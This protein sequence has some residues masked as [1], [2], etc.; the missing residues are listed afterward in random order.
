MKTKFMAMIL[1]GVM[2]FGFAFSTQLFAD[3]ASS[4]API[5]RVVTVHHG[6]LSEVNVAALEQSAGLLRADH[7]ELAAELEKMAASAVA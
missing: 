4:K 5:S 6:K 3:T 7:P 2:V 1:A